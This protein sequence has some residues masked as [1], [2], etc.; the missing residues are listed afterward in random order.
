M[1][2]YRAAARRAARRAG[3]DP[4]I[5][6]RQIT[7]ESGFDPN[8]HSPAGALG[9]AQMMPATARGW[10]VNPLDPVPA[11]NVAAKNMANYVRQ[12][13]GYENALRA[14]NAGPGNIARSRGFA[15]TNAY[16]K[17]I[18]GGANPKGL[19][20]P[21]RS[22]PRASSR[23]SSPKAAGSPI[24]TAQV[25]EQ[26]F[27]P[28][29]LPQRPQRQI[30]APTPPSFA[31]GATMSQGSAAPA[32][33]TYNPPKRLDVAA[34]VSA[35]ARP[36]LTTTTTTTSG[37]KRGGGGKSS[38]GGDGGGPKP[39]TRVKGT[40][41][42]EGHT[43]A[44]WIKPALVYARKQGWKGE[45][46]S[47]YRSYAEQM[48]IYNSGIRPAARPGTSNHEGSEFPRGA[49]DVTDAAQLS[50]ILRRSRFAKT[51]IWAGG[52]DPPHFSHPHN[53]SY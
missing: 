51:L 49:V 2:D 39:N 13:G 32:V 42:F 30:T 27:A 44:A 3:L 35:L 36:S 11:L 21:R 20:T 43:V 29:T 41:N 12:Y 47:G 16:V 23:A 9:I 28:V 45:I 7:Q 19:S 18:L 22:S 53:G 24:T 31:A 25:T 1:P 17:A 33:S 26:A 15:E 6:V 48:R 52:K 40:A 14:Y 4:N 5:F 10:G 37:G 34:A 46:N 8:A 50:A 38:G